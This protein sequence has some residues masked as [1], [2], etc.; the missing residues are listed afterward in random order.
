MHR[1][2]ADRR[3]SRLTNRL[4]QMAAAPAPKKKSTAKSKAA[5]TQ[6]EE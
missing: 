2:T 6:S 1:N 5:K 3:K 4:N